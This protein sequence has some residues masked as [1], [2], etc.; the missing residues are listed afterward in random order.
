MCDR[1]EARSL[2]Q[3]Q[4]SVALLIASGGKGEVVDPDQRRRQFDEWLMEEPKPV[5]PE[6]VRRQELL[7][8][9]GLKRG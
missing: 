1:I 3:H 7:Q 9:L 2:A 6:D 8:A 5:D 4:T